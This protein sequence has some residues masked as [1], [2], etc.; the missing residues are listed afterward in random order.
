LQYLTP[1]M[2]FVIGVAVFGEQMPAARWW[3]FALVWVALVVLTTDGLR[4]G[5]AP[6]PQPATVSQ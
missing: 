2:Q 1:T 6:R 5:R 4:A 3:G